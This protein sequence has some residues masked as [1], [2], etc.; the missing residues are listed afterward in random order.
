MYLIPCFPQ[1]GRITSVNNK[2]KKLSKAAQISQEVEDGA[3]MW[4]DAVANKLSEHEVLTL[5]EKMLVS[6]LNLFCY[7]SLS[8]G[9]SLLK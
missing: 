6:L 5:F 1:L 8:I 7:C 2:G 4:P 9:Y 3:Q